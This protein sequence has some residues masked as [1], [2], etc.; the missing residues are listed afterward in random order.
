MLHKIY[1]K[2]SEIKMEAKHETFEILLKYL[3]P[4]LF[5]SNVKDAEMEE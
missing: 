2:I 4:D 1:Y 3:D 5:V